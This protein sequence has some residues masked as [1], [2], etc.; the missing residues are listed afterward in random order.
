MFA[1]GLDLL[2]S[3]NIFVDFKRSCGALQTDLCC[4]C[5]EMGHMHPGIGMMQR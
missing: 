4:L 1:I 5:V 2:C 3:N